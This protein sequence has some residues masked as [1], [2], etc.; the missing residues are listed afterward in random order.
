MTTYMLVIYILMNGVWYTADS[1]IE[2]YNPTFYT[3]KEE[4]LEVATLATIIEKRQRE[5]KESQWIDPRKF[6]CIAMMQ[7][8]K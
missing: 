5:R 6:E 1:V 8:Q 7:H 3:S 4:C 2:G